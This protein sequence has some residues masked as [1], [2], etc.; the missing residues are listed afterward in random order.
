ML[1]TIEA[2]LRAN[3]DATKRTGI[4]FWV[5]VLGK[6]AFAPQVH[7]VVLH[8]IASALWH[9]PLR[10]LALA[11]R[12]LGVVWSGAEIHPAAQL[13]PGFVLVH[14]TGVVVG[15][16][17]V[18]GRNCR[19]HQGATLG[20]PGLDWR[21]DKAGY[22]TLGDHVILGAHAVVLGPCHIGDGA[23]IGANTTV[24]QDVAPNDVVAGSP[25]Q[26]VRTLTPVAD[27]PGDVLP[28]A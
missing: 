13:G 1:S 22:P 20:D 27:R 21:G 7:A 11:V 12:A 23:V 18:V 25:A 9:S 10:P 26:V 19:M 15:P 14:S 2:D 24:T 17:A 5:W 8:R 4:G 28:P 3:V 16:G 6:A